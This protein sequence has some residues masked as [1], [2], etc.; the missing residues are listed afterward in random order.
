MPKDCINC[1]TKMRSDKRADVCQPCAS[2]CECGKRKDF[3]VKKCMSCSFS[4]KAKRQWKEKSSTILAGIRRAGK[5]RRRTYDKIDWD[6]FCFKKTDGRRY[7][8]YWKNESELGYVYRYRWLWEQS[9]GP[10]PEGMVIHHINGDMT[11]DRLENLELMPSDE[12]GRH[13][14]SKQPNPDKTCTNCGKDRSHT[15]NRLYCS[16][17]C[18]L[19]N[20]GKI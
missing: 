3:R 10:I 8:S 4:D 14:Q 2:I 16:R 11:D 19:M 18:Y 7:T 12:H 15:K 1:G 9:N 17:A 6:S 13:H 20:T 5:A